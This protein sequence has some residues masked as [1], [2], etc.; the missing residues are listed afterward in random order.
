MNLSY[1][2]C[3]IYFIFWIIS[4]SNDILNYVFFRRWGTATLT[5][6]TTDRP[7]RTYIIRNGIWTI[8][9]GIIQYPI[10]KQAYNIYTE[11]FST[12][13]CIGQEASNFSSSVSIFTTLGGTFVAKYIL[14]SKWIP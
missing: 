5:V 2:V 9:N 1:L 7:P 13:R 12:L 4:Y 8:C 14:I 11:L 6:S 10:V 3:F